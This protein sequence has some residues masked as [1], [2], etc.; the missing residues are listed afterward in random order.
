MEEFMT[1]VEDIVIQ[2]GNEAGKIVL[3]LPKPKLNQ[4]IKVTRTL[5]NPLTIEIQI[6]DPELI[7]K[8][9]GN[10]NSIGESEMVPLGEWDKT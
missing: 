1:E 6:S 7:E 3:S 8:K 9:I 2:T 4:T 10:D 5:D